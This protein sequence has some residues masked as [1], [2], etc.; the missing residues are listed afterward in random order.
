MSKNKVRDNFRHGVL[1]RDD[2]KCRICGEPAV[3]AHHITDRHE[4]PNDGYV[5]ENGISLCAHCHLEAEQ[6]HIT[7]GKDWKQGKHPD[8][9]YQMIGS[10]KT[11]A[12]VKSMFLTNG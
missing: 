11:E 3:D 5:L 12:I 4:M 10:S 2:F 6:F 7:S 1:K 9:L 8:D